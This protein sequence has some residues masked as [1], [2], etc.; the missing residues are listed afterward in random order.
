MT[1][2]LT[3]VVYSCC[4]NAFLLGSIPALNWYFR[5][6][7]KGKKQIERLTCFEWGGKVLRFNV[8]FGKKN[9]L[10]SAHTHTHS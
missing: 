4:F 3:K 9:T 6:S 2:P 5:E 7:D 1:V 10:I 8:G